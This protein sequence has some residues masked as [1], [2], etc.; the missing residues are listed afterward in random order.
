MQLGNPNNVGVE[1]LR[2]STISSW[3]QLDPLRGFDRGLVKRLETVF[4]P[5]VDEKFLELIKKLVWPQHKDISDTGQVFVLDGQNAN[6]FKVCCG[7][8]AYLKSACAAPCRT[9]ARALC[10]LYNDY[11]KVVAGY[12]IRD[13]LKSE[14]D[15]LIISSLDS[16]EGDRLKDK[17]SAIISARLTSRVITILESE[18]ADVTLDEFRFL[19]SSFNE[20][21]VTVW[22]KRT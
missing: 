13:L 21:L 8:I 22:P 17:L 7:L 18:N 4:D 15:L 19:K 9:D 10:E 6:A 12:P 1:F 5:P 11:T 20:R 3:A 16:F 2:N 14:L